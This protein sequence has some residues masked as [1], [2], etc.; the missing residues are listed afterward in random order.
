MMVFSGFNL[1]YVKP[2]V[3]EEEAA[4]RLQGN[5]SWVIGLAVLVMVVVGL[6]GQIAPGGNGN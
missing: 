6:L 5:V 4:R 1:L 3:R 2:R